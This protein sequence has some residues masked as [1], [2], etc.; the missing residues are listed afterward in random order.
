MLLFR[1][2]LE[3][4]MGS[5]YQSKL[6]SCVLTFPKILISCAE[7]FIFIYLHLSHYLL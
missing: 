4:L 6:K 3:A 7:W 1:P 2:K 5:F